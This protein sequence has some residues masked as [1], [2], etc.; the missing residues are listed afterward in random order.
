MVPE[1]HRGSYFCLRTQILVFPCL[2]ECNFVCWNLAPLV[3][4]RFRIFAVFDQGLFSLFL[5]PILSFSAVLI[6]VFF[7]SRYFF[8]FDYFLFIYWDW[9]KIS[10]LPIFCLRAVFFY[11]SF[12]IQGIAYDFFV[13]D[14]FSYLHY[15]SSRSKD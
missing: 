2:S 15:L 1:P 6:S 14:F 13:S 9:E 7:S 4:F 11:Y 10:L 5:L 8:T 3:L 12:F